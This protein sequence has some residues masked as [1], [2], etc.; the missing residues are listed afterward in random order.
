MVLVRLKGFGK[1][2]IP[3]SLEI[4]KYYKLKLQSIYVY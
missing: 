2:K 4:E 1:L 3:M